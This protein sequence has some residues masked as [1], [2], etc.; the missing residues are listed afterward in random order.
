MQSFCNHYEKTNE[1]DKKQN[2]ATKY[3]CVS[4]VPQLVSN[5][6]KE[7]DRTKTREHIP[8]IDH[9]DPRG[10]GQGEVQLPVQVGPVGQRDFLTTM[11]INQWTKSVTA[12][13]LCSADCTPCHATLGN[14]AQFLSKATELYCQVNQGLINY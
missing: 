8:V 2:M 12:Q 10:S 13:E 7:S 4:H 6:R 1:A 5:Y 11:S 14:G 9:G 3:C